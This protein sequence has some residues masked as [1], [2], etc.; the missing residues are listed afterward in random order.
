MG[1]SA[2]V[3]EV[4]LGQVFALYVSPV[5]ALCVSSVFVLC[6]SSVFVFG[7]TPE[8]PAR[9]LGRNPFCPS[10]LSLIYICPL[11]ALLPHTHLRFRQTNTKL[12]PRSQYENKKNT[13]NPLLN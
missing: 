13:L 1:G 2:G 9:G 3:S 10:R 7:V 8:L 11:M 5:F 4:C 12:L 6:V